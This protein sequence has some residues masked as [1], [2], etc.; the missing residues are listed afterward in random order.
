M[1]VGLIAVVACASPREQSVRCGSCF[2]ISQV[3]VLHELHHVMS[4][5]GGRDA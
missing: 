5:R 4:A 1:F 3:V 2:R